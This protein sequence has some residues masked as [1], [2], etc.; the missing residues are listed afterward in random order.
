M[1]K[2][3]KKNLRNIG[4]FL[5]IIILLGVIY[6]FAILQSVIGGTGIGTN[7]DYTQV[8]LIENTPQ[9]ITYK[10]DWNYFGS[11]SNKCSNNLKKDLDLKY[12]TGYIAQS[13][14]KTVW[15]PTNF[16]N[17]PQT[18]KAESVKL[19]KI[20]L[21]GNPC[22]DVRYSGGINIINKDISA[23][24]TLSGGDTNSRYG[25]EAKIICDRSEE[26]RVGKECRSRW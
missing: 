5:S 15:L 12:K 26:R 7:L 3:T 25:T 24:C 17:I 2:R 19:T 14:Q 9:Y 11:Y 1:K 18:Q 8:T 22:G 23:T 13:L 10:I 16:G 6:Y 4:I 20:N 21:R